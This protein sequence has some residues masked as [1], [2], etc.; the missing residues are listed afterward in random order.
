MIIVAIAE[1]FTADI[2]EYQML[3]FIRLSQNNVSLYVGLLTMTWEIW[4]M[5]RLYTVKYFRRFYG[6]VTADWL[7]QECDLGRR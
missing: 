1:L 5:V 6:E 2:I 4:M 3:L 7:L